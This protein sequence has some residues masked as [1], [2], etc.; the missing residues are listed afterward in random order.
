MRDAEF[1]NLVYLTNPYKWESE[2]RD[3]FAYEQVRE[4]KPKSVIDIGCGNGHT[5]KYFSER[6]DAEFYGTDLSDEAVWLANHNLPGKYYVGDF[7]D[8]ELPHC[9]LALCMGVAEHFENLVDFLV[10]LGNT[11][12]IIYL[13]VPNCLSYS[14]SKEEGFR[15]TNEGSDQEEWHLTHDSWEKRIGYAGLE[16]LK[17][18]QGQTKATEFV[19]ILCHTKS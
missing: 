4:Y 1:Y 8:L 9:D 16:I 19:W 10:K 15:M 3:D 12:D 13:E 6:M 18:I 11:A 7:M 2:S 14:D 17:T 5:L